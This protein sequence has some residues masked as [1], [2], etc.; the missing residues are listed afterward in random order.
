MKHFTFLLINIFILCEYIMAD[1]NSQVLVINSNISLFEIGSD[2][3]YIDL[4]FHHPITMINASTILPFFVINSD[5]T[6]FT[7]AFNRNNIVKAIFARAPFG[8]V[9]RKEFRTPENVFIGMSYSELLELFPN[10]ILTKIHGWAYEYLLPSGW[11]IGF[12]TGG[13][14][15]DYFPAYEEKISMIYKN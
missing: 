7:I 8:L 4:N 10:V 12:I 14:G 13:S 5:G 2:I 1:E 6:Y 15:T 11:R 3:S 9:S